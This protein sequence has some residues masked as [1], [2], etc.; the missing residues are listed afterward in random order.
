MSFRGVAVV[1]AGLLLAAT[2][3]Y[4]TYIAVWAYPFD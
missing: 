2:A 4:L 1:L 3:A